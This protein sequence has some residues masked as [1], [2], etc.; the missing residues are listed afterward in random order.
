MCCQSFAVA[1]GART[2]IGGL[3]LGVWQGDAVRDVAQEGDGGV[4][5]LLGH[6]AARVAVGRREE[7][8]QLE[9]HVSRPKR[10]ALALQWQ[11]CVV[12][13]SVALGELFPRR[14]AAL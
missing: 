4:E 9:R 2:F 7:A 8:A 14:V 1:R 12:V 3:A 5:G 11:Q 10:A 13:I 6:L